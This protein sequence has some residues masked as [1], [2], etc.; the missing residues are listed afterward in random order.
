MRRIG[1]AVVLTLSLFAASLAA[2][3]QQGERVYRIGL[4]SEG[5]HPLSK[6]IADA[7]RELG[8]IEGKNLKFERRSADRADELPSLAAEL[9][10]L[11]VD[12]VLANGT[13]ATRAAKEAT[14]AIP[15]V[16]NLGE[17]PVANALV[18]SFA[19]PGG[20]L[21]GFV[22]GLYDEK[23]LEVLKE[24]LPALRRVAYPAPGGPG[25]DERRARAERF[26]GLHAAAP[27]LGVEV[28][29]IPVQGP[30]DLDGFFA[31]ARRAGAGAVLVVNIAWFRPYL[32]R[33]G[34][35]SLKSRLP[36]IGYYRQ[37]AEA[38]GLLSY[39]P[40]PFENVPR[41][42]AQIDKILKGA[43]PADLP[44]EQPTKFELVV[45]L[46]TAKAL[47]LTIP[48]SVLGRADQVID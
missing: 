8:W 43:R 13:R 48:P 21:T 46:K 25:A 12:L 28:Q 22:V 5:A 4:L 1:R 23:A 2:G 6:P 17:D 29:G 34:T 33:I 47:G 42:A 40:A 7:L 38:G 19:R 35:A 32:D 15:I 37:F 45:N 30:S 18:A 41:L 24:A 10:R 11:K 9:V 14:K 20:K 3:A 26:A 39:G 36:A 31:A 44:V 27:V 16:F